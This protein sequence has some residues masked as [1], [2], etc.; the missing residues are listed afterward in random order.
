MAETPDNG[1]IVASFLRLREE[2]SAMAKQFD[3]IL[4]GYDEKMIRLQAHLLDQMNK[5]NLKGLRTEFGTV[6]KE[7][8]IIPTANDWDALYSWIAETNSFEALERRVKKTFVKEYMEI[9]KGAIPPGVTV[10]RS[11]KAT[12]KKAQTRKGTP[13]DGD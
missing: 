7:E 12:I 6:T 8:D 9:N 10:L 4:D 2:K 3:A 5:Q 1:R 13:P 11:Y